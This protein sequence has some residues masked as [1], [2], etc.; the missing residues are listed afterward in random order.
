ME[1]APTAPTLTASRPDFG[2]AWETTLW[3]LTITPTGYS[4]PGMCGPQT[5]ALLS[6]VVVMAIGRSGESI[7]LLFDV[8]NSMDPT[9]YLGK[10]TADGLFTGS[11]PSWR[12][13]LPC[14]GTSIDWRG[15]ASVSGRFSENGRSLTA[16]EVHSFAL[17]RERHFF[18]SIL[19]GLPFSSER[20]NLDQLTD[21]NMLR[22][23]LF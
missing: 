19:I 8:R 20:R 12:G 5:E 22:R 14:N 4:W 10:V 15:E 16:R 11:M 13:S 3:T 7:Q 9:E 21:R 2:P 6:E 17:Y 18:A 1:V 23:G